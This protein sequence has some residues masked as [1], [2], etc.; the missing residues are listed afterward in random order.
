ML[1]K[2]LFASG[3]SLSGTMRPLQDAR[4]TTGRLYRVEIGGTNHIAKIVDDPTR[5]PQAVRELDVLTRLSTPLATVMPSLVTSLV[6][7]HTTVLVLEE[8]IGRH[9]S[10]RHHLDAADVERT[11]DGMTAV[12][13]MEAPEVTA[14]GVALPTWGQG[15]DV[16]RALH[17]RRARFDRR[18]DAFQHHH[19]RVAA[20][21][22]HLLSAVG[23]LLEAAAR[24]RIETPRLERPRLVH[25]DLH[26]D[27]LIIAPTGIRLLDW[28]TAS[29][30]DPIDDLVRFEMEARPGCRLADLERSARRLHGPRPGRHHVSDAVVLAYAGLVSGLAGRA[31]AEHTNHEHAVFERLLEPTHLIDVVAEAVDH[32]G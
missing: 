17:R 19:P 18:A 8:L 7:N 20:P 4:S 16:K 15:P 22:R 31:A 10:S 13:A 26:P 11:I 21:H 14:T 12:W 2:A 5:H 29:L 23:P 30:G 28:Q 25:G 9:P 32:L 1:E 24:R 27:N 6:E 3:L